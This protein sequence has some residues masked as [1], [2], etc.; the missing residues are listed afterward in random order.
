MCAVLANSS[1]VCW[2]LNHLGQLGDTSKTNRDHPVVV[3]SLDHGGALT[4]VV[5]IDA[6]NSHS[7]AVLS[8]GSAACWGND[9]YGQL[10]DGTTGPANVYTWPYP[11]AVIDLSPSGRL[12]G[13]TQ[14]TV[15]SLNSCAAL[16]DGTVNCWGRNEVHQ[17]GDTSPADRYFAGPV[18]GLAIVAALSDFIPLNPARALDTRIGGSTF[19]GLFAG[20]GTLGAKQTMTLDIGGRGGVAFNAAAVALNIAVTGPVG[21]GYLTVYPCDPTP[22]NASNL[23]YNAGDTIANLVITK[24]SPTGKICIY[25]DATTNIIVDINGYYP[26]SA[27]FVSTSPKRFVDTRQGGVTVD[28]QNEGLGIT[29]SGQTTTVTIGGRSGIPADATAVVMNITATGPTAGGYITVYPCDQGRPNASNLN[30]AAGQT[31]PNLTITKIGALGKICIYT[32]SPTH[33]IADVDG[34]YPSGSPYTPLQPTRLADTR[35][36]GVTIDGQYANT[37]PVQHDTEI[38][39]ATTNRTGTPA[40]ASAVVLNITITNP[41]SGGYITVYPCGTPKPNASNLNYNAGQTIANLVITKPGSEGKT[42]INTSATTN[43]I[44]DINGYYP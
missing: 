29:V 32:D 43:I 42:C 20:G 16:T 25:T 39:L 2:G 22:P 8:D 13:V 31:I 34:Y 38:Q 1:A 12:A 27:S 40:A 33:L 4:G 9:V 17:L 10:G 19:D 44:T 37:G 11:V 14:I 5:Q 15:G 35:V 21:G 36:G 3:V 30:Y 7:C 6:A 23:N 26:Y 24:L 41:Q 18:V 28:H